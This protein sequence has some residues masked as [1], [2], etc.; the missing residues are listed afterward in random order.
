[1]KY[2]HL[3]WRNMLRRKFRTTMTLL[4]I[5]VSFLLFGILMVIRVAFSMGVEV[6]GVDRLMMTN[7]ISIIQPLP[8]SYLPRIQAVPNVTMVSHASWFGG[9]YQDPSTN[10]FEFAVEP[11]TYLKMYPEFKLPPEQLKAWLADRQGFIAGRDLATRLGWKIG[12]RI[13]IK[14]TFNRPRGGDGTTW[15]FNLV[16]IYDG[17]KDVDKTQ[18]LFRYDYLDE[19]RTNGRGMTGWYL[20]KVADPAKSAETATSIDALFQNSSAET[21]TATEKAVAQSFANQVGDIG[22]I[23]TYVAAVVLF[24]ILLIAANTMALSVRERTSELGAM[25]AMGFGDSTLLGLVLFESVTLTLIGG[26][27]GLFMAWL[28]ALQGD[29]TG[30]FLP[31]F[32]LSGKDMVLGF[33]LAIVIGTLAGA[34]PAVAAMR[35]R[36]T[37]A[38]RRS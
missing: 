30:G 3:V 34:I 4:S 1:M 23:M 12:D 2:A 18:F 25:K 9:I 26:A 5:F 8:I 28:F 32:A 10:V 14:G 24:I 20:I 21:K 6:A 27:L 31:V 15:E 37:D 38:L 11:E 33:V 7:K 17:A 35:L 19:T 22:A 36:I 29:P 13:P 16:G